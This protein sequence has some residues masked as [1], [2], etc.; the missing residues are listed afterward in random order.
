[1]PL[2]PVFDKALVFA[3]IF[4]AL[5]PA[6][7]PRAEIDTDFEAI[8][9]HGAISNLFNDSNNVD[10]VYDAVKTEFG[11]YPFSNLVVNVENEYTY[12]EKT[13]GLS[14]F[15]GKGGFTFIPTREES[16]LSIYLT[17]LFGSRVYRDDFRSYNND[18]YD[19]GLFLGYQV[20]S[21]LNLRTGISYNEEVYTN[22]GDDRQSEDEIQ[23][24]FD[25][26]A[27]NKTYEFIIGANA[28]L[29]GFAA[30][31]LEA[32][33][34]TMALRYVS[35]P[36]DS[37][38]DISVG[39]FIL[40]NYLN[41][42][43]DTLRE[44]D[45]EAVYF[46]P[47]LS[48]QLGSK[49]GLNIIFIYRN[50]KNP[51]RIIIPGLST[52]FLSPWAAVYEGSALALNVKTFLVP[53]FIVTFGSGYW[54]KDFLIGEEEKVRRLLPDFIITDRHDEQNKVYISIQK[55]FKL[56]SGLHLEAVLLLDHSHNQSSN[57]YYDHDRQSISAAI[58][59]R[60]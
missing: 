56:K 16:P 39:D 2:R 22:E 24:T 8:L 49:L 18:V 14:N 12:Y 52:R 36:T 40:R 32:G 23:T 41:P 48:Y 11:F 13:G 33:F 6:G 44:G 46:S 53:G 57:D 10:D 7:S 30:I 1:M 59:L 15:F 9:S 60:I 58:N 31:D 43:K 20:N 4:L 3:A 21:F 26:P 25:I 5:M 29:G 37:M 55:P 51:D 42:N 47:R 28:S 35:P 54:Y 38:F 27:D 34:E 19:A 17:G 50:F 45:L